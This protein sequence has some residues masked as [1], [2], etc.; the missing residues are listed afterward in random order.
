MR[1]M[2]IETKPNAFCVSRST[3]MLFNHHTTVPPTHRF[4]PTLVLQS[5]QTK[6]LSDVQHHPPRRAGRS[7]TLDGDEIIA[8]SGHEA[9]ASVRR[10]SLWGGA[11]RLISQDGVCGSCREHSKWTFTIEMILSVAA[12][13]IAD[14]FDA[15]RA[16]WGG[17]SY[18]VKSLK[19]IKTFRSCR[20]FCAF[21]MR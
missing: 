2:F 18:E 5:V 10:A 12:V 14:G 9:S 1:V 4:T 6:I 8:S 20:E 15:G 21:R 16:A 11:D 19:K 7:Q 3:Y 13:S 17:V